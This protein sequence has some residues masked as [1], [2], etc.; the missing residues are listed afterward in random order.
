MLNNASVWQHVLPLLPSDWSV[1]IANVLTQDSM[2]S[3]A[4]DAW[5][6]LDDLKEDQ[7][8]IIAGFSLGGP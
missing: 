5:K 2:T 4:H 6:L 7:A 1:R 3:M 8:L